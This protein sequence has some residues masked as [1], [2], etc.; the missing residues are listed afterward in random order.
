MDGMHVVGA[1]GQHRDLA[2]LFERASDRI[3]DRV[4]PTLVIG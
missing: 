2:S 1:F 4:G 3:D